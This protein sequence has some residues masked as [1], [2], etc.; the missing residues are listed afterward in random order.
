MNTRTVTTK[1]GVAAAFILLSSG[2]T[3]CGSDMSNTAATAARAPVETSA[4][5]A[6][7]TSTAV[8]DTVAVTSPPES[9]TVS[10][11][12]ATEPPPE[13]VEKG[14][15]LPTDPFGTDNGNAG[16]P[17][18][19]K[20]TAPELAVVKPT[21]TDNP[22]VL[23]ATYSNSKG[24]TFSITV[25]SDVATS[26]QEFLTLPLCLEVVPARGFTDTNSATAT[27]GDVETELAKL[28]EDALGPDNTVPSEALKSEI[29]GFLG[30]LDNPDEIPGTGERVISIEPNLVCTDGTCAGNVTVGEPATVYLVVDPTVAPGYYDTYSVKTA[31][32]VSALLQ[33]GRGTIFAAIRNSTNWVAQAS[34]AASTGNYT[35][36]MQV[37]QSPAGGHFLSVYAYLSNPWVAVYSVWGTWQ[38][39]SY[40]K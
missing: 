29:D 6:S 30:G 25:S 28:A 15:G 31:T 11:S 18:L 10:T 26:V 33:S 14:K 3:A 27:L 38:I 32:Y 40:G 17:D 24:Q 37:W 5:S 36:Q 19:C 1:C 35:S 20:S 16:G 34:G 39:E 4:V 9:T 8:T 12:P 23:N 22:N 13:P 21:N 7:A 2:I